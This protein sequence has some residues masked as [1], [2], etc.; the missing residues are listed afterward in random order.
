M[1]RSSTIHDVLV[2]GAGHAGCE[3]ALAAAKLGCN[4]MLINPNL[5]HCALMACNPSLGGPGKAHLIKEIDALGGIMGLNAD[6][7]ALQMRK[8]NTSKGPA[9]QALRAQVDKNA[10]QRG[11]K[12]ILENQPGLLLREGTVE[13]IV[14]EEGAVRGVRTRGGSFYAGK[15]VVLSTGVYLR[16][17]IFVGHEHFP[18]GPGN[19][20][21]SIGLADNLLSL[22]FAVQ[23]FHTSTPPR[24][25]RD[26]MDLERL[27]PI[28]GEQG[29]GSF[30]YATPPQE[31][32]AVPCYLA[33]TGEETHRLILDNINHALIYSGLADS[34]GPR[35]CPSIE[36]KLVRFPERSRHPIFVE[37]ESLESAE[38]YLQ[39][40]STGLPEELQQ[41]FLRTIPGMEEVI[42]TRPAYAIGYDYLPPSQLKLSLETK[43][44][45]GLFLAGQINGTTG[46]EEAAAQGLVAGINAAL[47]SRK[48]PAFI[49]PRTEAY[50][51]VLIDDL[52]NKDIT[53]PYRMFTSRCEY[54]LMLR[55]DNADLRL[56]EKGF[57]L[58]L[59]GAER[60]RIFREKE[61]LLGEERK[62]L[63]SLRLT[64]S[65]RINEKLV[66]IGSSPLSQPQTLAEI[67]KRPEIGFA[68]LAGLAADRDTDFA[69]DPEIIS[70]V[71]TSI[72]YEGYLIKQ[73]NSIKEMLKM[74]KRRIP[75]D[76]P[77]ERLTNISAEARQK[78][79]DI[80]PLTLGQASRIDGVTPADISFLA[81]RLADRRAGSR[82]RKGNVEIEEKE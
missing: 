24:V 70:E 21:P 10:Y 50:I 37:P 47:K 6:L 25:Y 36:D 38:M 77:Y 71:E 64:P 1:S 62:K 34:K 14:V 31:F 44:V 19:Q 76:F 12:S 8:L 43:L 53:E 79:A 69:E 26:S 33:Y 59:I 5:D 81:L 28:E 67:L 55:H 54:R 82:Q 61:R 30:S 9:V 20:I 29:V 49:L 18:S 73:R 32:E 51:G 35:Y 4:T 39:G 72:K 58:G 40:V 15:T 74:E 66:S 65:G 27:V 23:R 78:L 42:I 41:A 22:G 52:I 60:Y 13:E 48:E 16:A 7:H 80:R 75:E 45:E 56:T 3:A 57:R 68:D 46:Y 63:E 17:E 11:M 2:I